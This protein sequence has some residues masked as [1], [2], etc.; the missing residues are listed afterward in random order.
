VRLASSLPLLTSSWVGHSASPGLLLMGFAGAFRRSELVALDVEDI[1]DTE[2]GLRIAVRRSKADQ[3]G[4]G[5]L[6][7][8]PSGSNPATCPGR[9]WR[10][11]LAASG[12]AEGPAFKAV[13]QKGELSSRRLAARAVA[14]VVKRRAKAAGQDAAASLP[15]RC[16]PASPPGPMARACPNSV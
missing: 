12:I 7:G 1:T 10:A 15:T 2:D 16:V 11:W 6:V 13:N 3:E 8:L 5:D 14:E 9:A 4:E